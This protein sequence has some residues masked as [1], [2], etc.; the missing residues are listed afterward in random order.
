M[1]HPELDNRLKVLRAERVKGKKTARLAVASKRSVPASPSQVAPKAVRPEKVA[2]LT[3]L[4]APIGFRD[5]GLLS[6]WTRTKSFD[7]DAL[8]RGPHGRSRRRTAPAPRSRPG[9]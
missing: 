4:A 2:S 1:G 9:R 5:D 6:R 3:L 8:G 7:L